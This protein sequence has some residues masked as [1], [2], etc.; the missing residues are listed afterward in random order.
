[1]YYPKSTRIQN[2]LLRA[3]PSFFN[4]FAVLAAFTTYF[5][6]YGFRKPFAVATFDGVV[7]LPF[8]GAVDYKILL[9]LLQVM[10]YMLSKFMGIKIVSELEPRKRAIGLL[11]MILTAH[12]ALLLFGIVPKPWNVIC[13]FFNGLPL[14]MVWGMVFG[15][16]EGRRSTELLG[17]GLSASYIVASGAV[18]SIGRVFL[19]AGVSEFWMPFVTGLVFLPVLLLAVFLLNSLPPPNEEDRRLRME[20]QPMDKAARHSF[21]KKF[22]PGLLA[23]TGLYILLT[24]YRDFRD[25]FSREIWDALGYPGRSDVYTLSEIPV[26]FV[27]LISLALIM[28]IKSN[29]L[30]LSVIHYVMIAGTGLIGVST[31]AFQAGLLNPGIW[32]TVVGLGLYL[33][34]VP[35]GCVLF[36]RLI[37]SVGVV[38][39]AGFMIYVTDAF[40]YLGSVGVLLYKNFGQ[41]EVSWFHFFIG[42]SY[43]T[44]VVCTAAFVFSLRYFQSHRDV[45]RGHFT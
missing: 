30:A 5:S 40:G 29:Q 38:G 11:T 17:A 31:L 20:R 19:N 13:L 27:V 4:A 6:M 9:I 12:V 24:A 33:A 44:A 16:L 25:N 10:G 42:F 2:W 36:D 7:E 21:V 43:V 37:A 8:G 14:G 26:A 39:T 41:S 3:R 32:M 15:F 1:M 23:L 22:A 34:Y 18:K 35:Y 28:K 45:N